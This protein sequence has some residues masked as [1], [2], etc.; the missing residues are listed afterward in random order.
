MKGKIKAVIAS[1]FVVFLFLFSSFV[2]L[3][4]RKVIYREMERS[5]RG[6]HNVYKQYIFSVDG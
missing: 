1:N 6:N 3:E 4:E 2:S 5:K